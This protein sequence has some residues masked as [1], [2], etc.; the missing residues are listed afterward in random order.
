MEFY[1]GQPEN[2]AASVRDYC[3]G[4]LKYPK[5]NDPFARLNWLDDEICRTNISTPTHDH[6]VI[7]EVVS[8]VLSRVSKGIRL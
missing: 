4:V 6:V 5:D 2:P 8:E 7:L 3:T 1:S